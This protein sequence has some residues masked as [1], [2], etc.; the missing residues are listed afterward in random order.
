LR[1]VAFGVLWGALSD[2]VQS[3][4][5]AAEVLRWPRMGEEAGIE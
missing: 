5:T 2:L 4:V 1:G 3:R